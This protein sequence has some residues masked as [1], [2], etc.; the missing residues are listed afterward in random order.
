VRGTSWVTH[1]NSLGKGAT[2]CDARSAFSR[3]WGGGPGFAARGGMR[4]THRLGRLFQGLVASVAPVSFVISALSCGGADETE[5]GG[6]WPAC[7]SPNPACI[8]CTRSIPDGVT[9]PIEADG[10]P[11]DT[12][13]GD[14]C[15][16]FC[17]SSTN[18]ADCRLDSRD[19]TGKTVVCGFACGG[20]RP[21]GFEGSAAHN[22]ADAG[23]FF[24][25]MARLEAASIQAFRTLRQE[26]VAHRAPR[27]L[28]RMAERAAR[29]EKR[30]TRMTSALARRF[31]AMLRDPEIPKPKPPLRSLEAI[32]IENAVE[33]CVRETFGALLATYQA[34]KA[35]DP[36]IR[37]AMARI[38][39][40]ET[41]H[42]AVAWRVAGWLNGKLDA[43]A[44]VAVSA[45]RRHARWEL[46]RSLR[47]APTEATAALGLPDAA[48]M[49]Q[50]AAR[51]DDALWSSAE[52][53][54]TD[55]SGA[56]RTRE[57]AVTSLI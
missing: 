27:G 14:A 29:D 8:Q 11:V 48:A 12:L 20:R 28:V 50:L 23:E 54:A 32:A 1:A 36:V 38:A 53:R 16:S 13:E 10:T 31:G 46:S 15:S 26:L 22:T 25:E 30:H 52:I 56:R 49:R 45:A 35:S 18:I 33:G 34:A 44:R 19:Q 37:A 21:S 24:S 9:W 47:A 3:I 7:V 6:E 51:L 17:S 55:R 41:R 40:D 57:P 43:H 42:A 2:N 4:T 39:R 5:K